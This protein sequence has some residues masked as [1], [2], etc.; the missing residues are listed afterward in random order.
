MQEKTTIVGCAPRD[1]KSLAIRSALNHS[2]SSP[3]K[4]NSARA[5]R[6][7]SFTSRYRPTTCLTLG[8]WTTAGSTR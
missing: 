1:P 6:L 2:R 4:S 5:P 3:L 7:M 8:P